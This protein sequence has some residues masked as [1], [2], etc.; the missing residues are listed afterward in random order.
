LVYLVGNVRSR[1]I[2]SILNPSYRAFRQLDVTIGGFAFLQ[3]F[4]IVAVESEAAQIAQLW[5]S[6]ELSDR[7]VTGDRFQSI[8]IGCEGKV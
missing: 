2:D 6:A 5:R 3:S 1:P 7:E 8:E 4:N